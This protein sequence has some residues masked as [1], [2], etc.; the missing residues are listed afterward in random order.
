MSHDEDHEGRTAIQWKGQLD[1]DR[2]CGAVSSDK[3]CWLCEDFPAWNTV[4]HALDLQLDEIAPA[5]LRLRFDYN[6]RRRDLV[7]ATREASIIVSS[8]L[9]H[10]L[11]VQEVHLQC[12]IS[13]NTAAAQPSFP[14][15][16]RA[17]TS[18][19]L[20]LRDMDAIIGL[21][22]LYIHIGRF[23]P[24]FGAEMDALLVRNRNTLKS[25]EIFESLQGLNKLG[26]VEHLAACKSL[27]LKSLSLRDTATP[28]VDGM[29]RKKVVGKTKMSHG[30][31][32]DA[33]AAIQWKRNLELDRPCGAVDS[34]ETC[35]LCDDFPAWNTVIYALDLV[36][37]ETAPG[38]LRLSF[39]P[40]TQEKEDLV[41]AAREASIVLTSLLRHHLCIQ[42]VY[43]ECAISSC[44]PA[45]QP[46]YPVF[47]CQN[48]GAHLDLRDM[49]AII[50]LETLDINIRRFSQCFAAELDAL[51]ERNCNT[52]KKRRPFG[53][54]FRTSLARQLLE[55]E[56][57]DRV[58]L[59]P[60]T[61]PYLRVLAPV[62]ASSEACI[63]ELWLPDICQ[64]SLETVSVVY[65]CLASN[66]VNRLTV[67]VFNE[68][69]YR[70]SHLCETLKNNRSIQ[71]LR[72]QMSNGNSANEILRA[73]SENTAITELS[74]RLWVP[75]LEET[76]TALS[77]MLSRNKAIT[78]IYVDLDSESTRRYLEAIAQGIS[79]N[80]LIISLGYCVPVGTYFPLGVFA[81][82][83][84]NRAAL[85]RAMDF[86]LERREDRHCAECFEL[87]FGRSC[88][89]TNLMEIG[90]MSDVEARI[91][92]TSAENRRRE[93]YLVLTGVVWSSVA[94]G[95]TDV[96]QID[97]LNSDCWRAI[98]RYLKVTDVR[99][100]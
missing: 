37:A 21:E 66:K 75:A 3:T 84:R 52:L 60:W 82:V 12:A 63:S 70:V 71:S 36:L 5:T 74:M 39:D 25:V 100:Q 49:G 67:A 93:K 38:T 53:S 65:K 54:C 69:D 88:L 68:P 79:G 19:H 43:L 89:I 98:A 96:T 97:A 85:N 28:H 26:M 33:S 22:K 76:M 16:M 14:I 32:H 30:E 91:G 51:L 99:S 92:V 87:F 59:G 7:T 56:C 46:S 58:R 2:S 47:M 44:T 1:L 35:W 61:E 27:T 9:R 57:Y 64:L 41:T 29:L 31:D 95:P 17:N 23:S 6:S 8:L 94:C 83:R 90:K 77:N 50:G 45:A 11:C 80:R 24:C 18:A 72:I 13:S 42:E 4:M 73:L 48:A 86:A 55:D 81:P 62:L 20:D 78:S 34:N 40:N 15:F 10:H